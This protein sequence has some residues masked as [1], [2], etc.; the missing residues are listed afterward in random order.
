MKK[1][2]INEIYY[3]IHGEGVRWGIPHIFIRFAKC[4]LSCKFCDTEF[5][6]YT[7]MTAQ[8]I[9]DAATR[10]TSW[11]TPLPT[12]GAVGGQIKGGMP[13]AHKD[14][15][16]LMLC[17]GEPLLQVDAE[18]VDLA[19]DQQWKMAIETNGTMKTPESKEVID[20]ITCSP[21]VAEHALK[22]VCA[23]ELKYVRAH[24]Q[25]IP[26]PKITSINYLLSPMF[27][28]DDVSRETLDWCV[29][30]VKRNPRWRLT[31]QHHKLSF[32]GMR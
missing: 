26:H 20:W 4:N 24:G 8:E 18:F 30:L 15:N 13:L 31:V 7:E 19:H 9:L 1:Y 29:N 22:L 21:K 10:I 2:L 11:Q 23:D 3:T 25:G 12:D 6:S 27:D 16:W 32:G 14:C 5:E 17:G 28:G